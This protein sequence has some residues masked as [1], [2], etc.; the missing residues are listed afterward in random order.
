[1]LTAWL[2]AGGSRIGEVA[3]R[4]AA[5]GFELRHWADGAGCRI[6]TGPAAAREIARYDAEGNYRPLKSAPNLQ[7]GWLLRVAD[8][9]ELRL[10]LDFIYPAM[11]GTWLAAQRGRLVPVDFRETAARQSGMYAVVK[12]MRAP[13][14]DALIGRFCR[15]DGGCLKTI[16]WR[17]EPGAPV[18]TL[19][20]MKFD[21]AF[22]QVTGARDES[23][24]RP[25]P[26][27]CAEP[28][29]LL[30]AAARAE[31]KRA[32]EPA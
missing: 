23:A 8:L 12:K 25:I 22:D 24:S 4:H 28:C 32:T 16:L 26:L 17:I 6:L 1:M 3:I 29:N 19:P 5:D 21:L 31:L 13:Q 11:I 7:R 10:A 30:I 14:A 27:P 9:A 15:S 18:S 20:P 2:E